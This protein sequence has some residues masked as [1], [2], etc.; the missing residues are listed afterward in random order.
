MAFF[1]GGMGGGGG[2]NT[3]FTPLQLSKGYVEYCLIKKTILKNILYYLSNRSLIKLYGQEHEPVALTE[4]N[5]STKRWEN[6]WH[7]RWEN[8]VERSSNALKILRRPEKRGE[9]NCNSVLKKSQS[10]LLN[11]LEKPFDK[12]L[13][14]LYNLFVFSCFI[15]SCLNLFVFQI[16]KGTVFYFVIFALF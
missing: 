1:W 3:P 4:I 5:N 9:E 12:I 8:S 6:L 15:D 10:Q 13:A 14:I 16:S 2:Q 7:S 11:W